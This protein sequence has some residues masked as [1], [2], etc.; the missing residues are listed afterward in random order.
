VAEALALAPAAALYLL[1]ARSTE[2]PLRRSAAFIAGLAMLG[3]AAGL[4]DHPLAR[5]MAAH[6]AIVCGA[7]PL[8]VLGAPVSLA[9]R[10][11]PR[12]QAREL[13]ALIRRPPL[14]WLVRPAFA[15]V[16]FVGLQLAFHVTP[17]FRIALHDPVVHGIE[18]ASFL[19][20]ALAF[21]DCA[22]GVDPI[23]RRPAAPLRALYL[24]AAMPAMDVAGVYLMAIGH[25]SAGAVM[26]AGSMPLGLAAGLVAWNW[27]ELEEGRAKRSE[28]LG[29][30]G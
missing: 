8:L 27:L 17:L 10:T 18:H 9:L 22:I 11:L 23:P 15:W 3:V 25:G 7:P 29:A 24:L 4:G 13:A 6:A 12:R 16:A 26:M 21:W 20:S 28:A 19:L 14:A 5:H 1:A 30:A 2:W